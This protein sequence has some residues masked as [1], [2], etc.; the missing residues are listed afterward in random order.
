MCNSYKPKHNGISFILLLLLRLETSAR[1][2][3]IV[4]RF[5]CSWSALTHTLM[6]F[7]SSS[8]WSL[9]KSRSLL[10]LIRYVWARHSFQFRIAEFKD[11]HGA[12]CNKLKKEYCFRFTLSVRVRV[13]LTHCSSAAANAKTVARLHE[14]VCVRGGSV[15]VRV[16]IFF[17]VLFLYFFAPFPWHFDSG[18]VCMPRYLRFQFHVL[19]RLK[20]FR[21]AAAAGR[22]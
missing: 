19:K 11:T 3:R 7:P 18:S 13:W 10:T 12:P 4:I 21:S 2:L 22:R 16:R 9:L 17:Y 1:P 15:C 20:R 6:G 14:C 5:A 8:R